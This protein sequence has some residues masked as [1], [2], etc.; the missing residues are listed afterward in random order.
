MNKVKHFDWRVKHNYKY[1]FQYHVSQEVILINK[2]A[3]LLVQHQ[4]GVR[5]V[6]W[7]LAS[8]V[9]LVKLWRLGKVP[10]RKP[11]NGVST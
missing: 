8:L 3:V 7:N 1:Y 9:S 10:L 11:A 6:W 2:V 4:V 5:E